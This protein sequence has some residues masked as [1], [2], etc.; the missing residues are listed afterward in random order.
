MLLLVAVVTGAL[1]SGGIGLALWHRGS[2]GGERL[3]AAGLLV[4]GAVF[5]WIATTPPVG[6]FPQHLLATTPASAGPAPG[7]LV[8]K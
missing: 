3:L 6:G 2:G 8:P 7:Y 5:A 4:L 1:V